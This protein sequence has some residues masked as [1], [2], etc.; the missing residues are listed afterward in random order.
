VN[1]R[2]SGPRS[3]RV[4]TPVLPPHT[5][6]MA[7]GLFGGSFNPPHAG[8]R[9]A[10]LIAMKRLRLDRLWWLVTPGNPLKNNAG[11][12]PLGERIAAARALADHPRIVVT[13]VEAGIGTRFTHD[14]LAHLT[15]RCPGV[16]FVW[17]MGADNLSGFRR[18]ERW[19]AIASL[20][21]I[22]VVDRPGSTLPATASLAAH[23]LGRHR[24][25]E[26]RAQSLVGASPPAW[27]FLH[28]P[29]SHLS[30]TTIRSRLAQTE[31]TRP[32]LAGGDG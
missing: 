27:T 13:G 26:A 23:A 29:R 28:G 18:W 11:L 10:C 30:S 12:P 7:I 5:P 17:I 22:A 4:L 16:D 8:H 19:R 32:R 2:S 31:T 3:G 25:P 24:L 1:Q 21:P 15:E 9:L 20:M 6:G 14:T